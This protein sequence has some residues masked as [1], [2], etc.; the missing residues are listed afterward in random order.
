MLPN[1]VNVAGDQANEP[2]FLISGLGGTAAFWAPVQQG[3]AASNFL[4]SYDQPGCGAR[5]HKSCEVSISGLARDAAEV[6]RSVFGNRCVTVIGHST[7]GA[8]AQ[9]IAVTEPDLV[10]RLVL[11]GTWLVAD[12]YMQA[13]FRYR[14][15]LLSRAPDLA[16]GLTEIL[17]QEPADFKCERLSPQPLAGIEIENNLNR[18]DALLAFDGTASVAQVLVK[19]L[20][21]GARNDR[22]V[23]VALQKALHSELPNSE[24]NIFPDGGHFFPKHR[25]ENFI[26]VVGSWLASED[27]LKAR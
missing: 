6:I 22:V 18:I 27:D 1:W 3:L 26:S 17:S 7:G 16:V 2:V 23:P 4:V 19:T 24:I 12:E 15:A 5:P 8:I 10:K 25:P 13:L 11:S 14:Q 9:Q 21:L 20:V